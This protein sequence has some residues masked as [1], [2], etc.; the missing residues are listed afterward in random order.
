VIG[1]YVARLMS[2]DPRVAGQAE[3]YDLKVR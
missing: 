1:K 2:F 3:L